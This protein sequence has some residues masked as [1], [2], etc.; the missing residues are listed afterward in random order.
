MKAAY[1]QN[2]DDFLKENLDPVLKL[3]GDQKRTLTQFEKYR[4]ITAFTGNEDLY[5]P[6]D[7][8]KQIPERLKT[9]F[10]DVGNLDP[11]VKARLDYANLINGQ[12]DIIQQMILDR[13]KANGDNSG[14]STDDLLLARTLSD[15]LAGELAEALTGDES[16]LATELRAEGSVSSFLAKKVQD[17]TVRFN[18][19]EFDGF[20]RKLNLLAVSKMKTYGKLI[21][22]ILAYYIVKLH[23]MEKLIG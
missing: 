2:L 6:A 3:A 8:N 1:Q 4:I 14:I 22:T 13:K 5:N 15:V 19:G 7:S 10:A 18:N 16:A 21:Q 12:S 17:L 11:D 9:L 20:A 23:T